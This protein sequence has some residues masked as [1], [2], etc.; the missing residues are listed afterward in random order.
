MTYRN[1]IANASGS[2][3]CAFLLFFIINRCQ[4]GNLVSLIDANYTHLLWLT[5][6]NYTNFLSLIDSIYANFLWLIDDNVYVSQTIKTFGECKFP[7]PC[8]VREQIMYEA[9]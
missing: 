8:E 4:N 9:I 7:V 2:N 6:A 3:I 1:D 5:D